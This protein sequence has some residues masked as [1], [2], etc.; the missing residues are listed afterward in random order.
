MTQGLGISIYIA[1]YQFMNYF[2]QSETHMQ[3]NLHVCIY[4]FVLTDDKLT[5]W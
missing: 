5:D 2:A 3:L 4:G 1:S